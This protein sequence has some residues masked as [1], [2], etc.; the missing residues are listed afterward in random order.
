MERSAGAWL[1]TG[2]TSARANSAATQPPARRRGGNT[3]ARL[4]RWMWNHNPNTSSSG[5]PR[6]TKT[7]SENS[8][9]LTAAVLRKLRVSGEPKTGSASSNSAVAMAENWP[10]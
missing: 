4:M 8:R 9:S 5:T 3:A 6:C 2:C 7:N 10:S 1:I